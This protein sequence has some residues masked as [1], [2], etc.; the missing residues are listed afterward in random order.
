[1]DCISDKDC[2]HGV[3]KKARC[4]TGFLPKGSRCTSSLNCSTWLDCLNGFCLPKDYLYP[5]SCVENYDC[6]HEDF[7][8]SGGKCYMSKYSGSTCSQE[9]ECQDGLSCYDGKCT[10]RCDDDHPCP[11]DDSCESVGD[12]YKICKKSSTPK[13]TPKT[14]STSAISC[15]SNKH[16]PSGSCRLGKCENQVERGVPCSSAEY[17]QEGLECNFFSDR[18]M[19]SGYRANFDNCSGD[20]DCLISCYCHHGSCKIK[21][22]AGDSCKTDNMCSDGLSCYQN[23][24]TPRCLPGVAECMSG[25]SC[26]TVYGQ[27]YKLCLTT[28][29]APAGHPLSFPFPSPPPPA[30]PTSTNQSKYS[31]ASM[32]FSVLIIVLLLVALIAFISFLVK[33]CCK[34]TATPNLN[35]RPSEPPLPPI[36]P[37][38]YA[39]SP[40][41]YVSPYMVPAYAPPSYSYSQEE[42]SPVTLPEKQ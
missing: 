37:M 19:E 30:N 2:T 17:C 16:C 40:A 36:N 15:T 1:M 14:F 25:D 39:T 22:T 12:A 28:K 23:K 8:C 33:K 34:S 21:N 4:N 7:Y 3:C 13:K 29:S 35:D 10:H 26:E 18:C 42:N 38:L 5:A 32:M 6:A 11:F 9:K 31:P 27:S 20:Y 41:P 24:C